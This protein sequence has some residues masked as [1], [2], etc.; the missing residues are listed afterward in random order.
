MCVCMGKIC[1]KIQQYEKSKTFRK[2]NLS[3]IPGK[4]YEIEFLMDVH[5]VLFFFDN[6]CWTFCLHKQT[7]NIP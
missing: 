2:I 3:Y 5:F 6:R 4:N 1:Y 7:I